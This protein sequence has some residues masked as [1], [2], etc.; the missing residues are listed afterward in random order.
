MTDDHTDTDTDTDNEEEYYDSYLRIL[1][2]SQ[3]LASALIDATIRDIDTG[4]QG[5]NTEYLNRDIVQIPM[6]ISNRRIP[7]LLLSSLYNDNQ[8]FYYETEEESRLLER[9]V[10]ESM[11]SYHNEMLR[12]NIKRRLSED[13]YLTHSFDAS[14]C[15]ND[16]CFICL[17]L[18]ENGDNV[19][20]L[21][22]CQHS[23]HEDCLK[24]MVQYNP[25]CALCK[26][27]INTFEDI[28]EQENGI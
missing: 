6:T 22:T 4:Q 28:V 19:C 23:F 12:K 26:A 16:K 27:D 5:R 18:F 14:K 15:R 24:N 1:D 21:T 9:A 17:E 8:V 25:V 3:T 10:E 13:S 2:A 11:N 20:S 7:L